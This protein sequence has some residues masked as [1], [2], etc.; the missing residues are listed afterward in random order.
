MGV[1]V[2]WG[3]PEKT[4]MCYEFTGM[5]NRDQLSAAYQEARTMAL[6]VSHRVDVMIVAPG[7]AMHHT[8]TTNSFILSLLRGGQRSARAG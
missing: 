5:W 4:L 6:S 1:Q 2:Y 7:S 8:I 3:N